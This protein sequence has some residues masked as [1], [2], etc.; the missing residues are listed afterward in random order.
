MWAYIDL[1][2]DSCNINDLVSICYET[3]PQSRVK[4]SCI[5][6]NENCSF[7]EVPCHPTKYVYHYSGVLLSGTDKLFYLKRN[8]ARNEK[9][10]VTK[11]FSK[12]GVAWVSWNEAEYVQYRDIKVESPSHITTVLTV[13]YPRQQ[14]QRWEETILNHSL[15]SSLKL[16]NFTGVLHQLDNLRVQMIDTHTP[17]HISWLVYANTCIILLVTCFVAY[18]HFGWVIRKFFMR[19]WVCVTIGARKGQGDKGHFKSLSDISPDETSE[20]QPGDI[21]VQAEQPPTIVIPN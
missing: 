21:K 8:A 3:V 6:D 16:G 11:S 1:N 17:A 13:A 2:E 19:C 14:L 10:I 5:H 9:R 7:T 4:S 18:L 12:L 20:L 15:Q